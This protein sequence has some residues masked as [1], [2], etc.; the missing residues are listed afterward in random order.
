M[1]LA[2]AGREAGVSPGSRG[3]RQ[4]ATGNDPD[5][6]PHGVVDDGD[7]L[8]GQQGGVGMGQCSARSYS[9]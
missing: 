8:L 4:D 5:A 2:P 6:V 9:A 1:G 7:A 3:F